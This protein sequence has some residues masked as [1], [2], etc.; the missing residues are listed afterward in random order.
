MNHPVLSFGP[1][2]Q[3]SGA[4]DAKREQFTILA[5]NIDTVIQILEAEPDPSAPAKKKFRHQY[6]VPVLGGVDENKTRS[7]SFLL[8]Q[9]GNSLMPER[10]E[11]SILNSRIIYNE[12]VHTPDEDHEFWALAYMRVVHGG[13]M[14]DDLVW[15]DAMIRKISNRVGSPMHPRYDIPFFPNIPVRV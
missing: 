7:I 12:L 4:A 14:R 6:V 13:A 2:T 15:R 9:K 8:Y 1:Y 5:E 3:E 10:F 11:S